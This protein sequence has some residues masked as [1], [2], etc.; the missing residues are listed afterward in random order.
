MRRA[1]ALISTHLFL[2]ALGAPGAYALDFFLSPQGSDGAS[3]T[4]PSTAWATLEKAHS[5]LLALKPAESVRI[6]VA[7]GKYYCAGVLSTWTYVSP[8]GHLV[9]IEARD[10]V[11]SP[12]VS[13]ANHASRPIFYGLNRD[14]TN[15]SKSIWLYLE[16][17]KVPVNLIIKGIKIAHYR[18]GIS[19]KGTSQEITRVD[20]NIQVLNTVFERI[21]DIYW[22]SSNAGKGAILLNYTFGNRF[23]DNYFF[24]IR[25]N[26]STAG[27]IHPFYLSS[28]SSRNSIIRNTIVGSSGSAIKVTHYSGINTILDNRFSYVAQAY[29]D[30]WCRSRTSP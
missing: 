13:S 23:E 9:T 12:A 19:V 15:C 17:A 21:G 20:Q 6:R 5:H 29:T 25:N 26:Y 7:P 4:S 27:L 18:G 8:G 24:Q 30:R 16:H 2:A 10:A 3:G 1:L 22:R 14:G 11:P 28:A